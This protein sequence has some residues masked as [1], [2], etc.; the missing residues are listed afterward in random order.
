MPTLTIRN[1][2]SSRVSVGQHVGSL[3][4][5]KTKV[6]DISARTLEE[7]RDSLVGLEAAGLISWDAANTATTA[8]DDAEFVTLADINSPSVVATAQVLD[9]ALT[10]NQDNFDDGGNLDSNNVLRVTSAGAAT[11][12]T[13]LAGGFPGR[14]LYLYDVD[15]TGFI[16]GHENASSLPENRMDLPGASDFAVTGNAGVQLLYDGAISRWV[17]IGRSTL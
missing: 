6:I 4:P 17:L 11:L 3:E 1:V 2:S 15:G 12:F 10:V 9:Y 16:L 7:S 5:G 14:V 8:D 13:G